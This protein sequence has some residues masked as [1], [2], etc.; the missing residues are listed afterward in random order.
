[1]E[2]VQLL[3]VE[4]VYSHYLLVH[5]MLDC[6]HPQLRIEYGMEW[7]AHFLYLMYLKVHWVVVQSWE[8]FR[9][10]GEQLKKLKGPAVRMLNL[11][12]VWGYSYKVMM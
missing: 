1:M 7:W 4:I 11:R 8:L 5:I 6:T 9:Y 3:A 2:Q 10:K 12:I